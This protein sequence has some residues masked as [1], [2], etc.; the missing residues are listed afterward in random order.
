[1]SI[2]TGGMRA[3]AL[4]LIRT[5]SERVPIHNIEQCLTGLKARAR[6]FWWLNKMRE[7]VAELPPD[8]FENF[9]ATFLTPDSEP[10][11]AKPDASITITL[12]RWL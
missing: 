8:Y 1:M 2:A 9:S 5:K 4:S 10:L 12:R 11:A 6:R 7:I 3:T